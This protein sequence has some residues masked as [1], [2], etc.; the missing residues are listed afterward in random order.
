MEYRSNGEMEWRSDGMIEEWSNG[1]FGVI[2]EWSIGVME[3]WDKKNWS[4]GAAE[5]WSIGISRFGTKRILEPLAFDP[6]ANSTGKAQRS[7]QKRRFLIWIGVS[8]L[9]FFLI[10]ETRRYRRVS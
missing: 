8:M 9:P 7:E 10:R 1:V 6:I 5:C 3:W 2:E 4:I